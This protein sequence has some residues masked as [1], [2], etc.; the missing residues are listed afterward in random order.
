[1]TVEEAQYTNPTVEP[2]FVVVIMRHRLLILASI[3][4]VTAFFALQLP[5]LRMYSEFNDL[6]P[7]KHPYIQLHN[8]IR[9]VFGGANIVLLAVEVEQGD[10]FQ[11]EV[12]DTIYRIT[13]EIDLLPGVDHN[14]IASLAHQKVRKIWITDTGTVL[15]QSFYDP[16]KPP[17]GEA[18][19][20]LREDVISSPRVYGRLVAPN[21]RS[22]LVTAH[23]HEGHLDYQQ[24]FDGLQKIRTDKVRPGLRIYATGQPVLMGWVYYYVHELF[25]IFS[26]T[27]VVIVVLL[28]YYFRRIFGVLVP[29]LCALLSAIWGLGFCAL[30]GYNLDPLTLVIPVLISARAVSHAVQFIER[31]YEEL[32]RYGESE[33]ASRATMAEMFLPGLLGI[34]TDASGLLLIAVGAFP[35]NTKLAY[36]STFW[37]ASISVTVILMLPLLLVYLPLP[38]DVQLKH[39]ALRRILPVIARV[40]TQNGSAWGIVGV[41][42]VL[43]VLALYFSTRLVVGTAQSGSP[44]LYPRSDYNLS[45]EVINREFPGSEELFIVAETPNKGDIKDPKVLRYLEGFQQH[46]LDDPE[47]GGTKSIADLVR[48]VNQINHHDDPKWAQIPR[49]AAFV[50]GV[51]FSYMASAPIP[52]SLDEYIDAHER[53]ANVVV[54]YKDHKGATI[55]RAIERV[56]SFMA[57]HPLDGV[58]LRLAGGLIGVTAAMNEEILSSNFTITALV[59]VSV[60]LFVALGYRSLVA[61]LLVSAPLALAALWGEAFLALMGIGLNVNTAPVTAVGIGVGVDYAIYIM[62]RIKQEY[63]RLGGLQAAAQEAIATSGMA[64]T[65]TASTLVGGIIFW[66][67]FS[68]LR[69]QAEMSLLL[70]ILMVTNMIGAMLLLPALTVLVR[71]AFI[72]GMV[73]KLERRQEALASVATREAGGTQ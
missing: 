69:F 32:E 62:D 29:L 9:D 59:F 5:G 22:A 16:Q 20:R 19:S 27:G 53:Q 11:P 51:L 47:V 33:L 42:A 1:M 3:F 17:Q 4:A 23:F 56:K 49:D 68:S 71:P 21:L 13:Q 36:Y 52:G 15:S 2:H 18:L 14:Q 31:F 38:R 40:C 54:Y 61:A 7:Q 37:A 10:I 39:N 24:I 65:F 50:G 30:M 28:T 64:V 70:S 6:L 43:M 41:S 34:V 8:E 72:V 73:E 57:A 46:M 45:A 44:I 25:L 63:A 35:L 55:E 48:L 58:S 60:F 12:L 67:F 66:A 26:L